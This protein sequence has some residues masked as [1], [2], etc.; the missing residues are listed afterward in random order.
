MLVITKKPVKLY[1]RRLS[2][3]SLGKVGKRDEIR[4]LMLFLEGEKIREPSTNSHLVKVFIKNLV[5]RVAKFVSIPYSTLRVD[6]K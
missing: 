5:W 6:H 3:V 1:I 4:P 2:Y